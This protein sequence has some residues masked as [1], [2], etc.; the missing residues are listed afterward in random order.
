[1]NE[2]KEIYDRITFL[3][4][5]GVKMKEMAEQTQLTPS[6]LSAM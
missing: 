5:K 4:K 1:M 6:V 3:R 2:L